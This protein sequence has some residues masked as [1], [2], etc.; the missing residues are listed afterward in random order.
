MNLSTPPLYSALAA[1]FSVDLVNNPPDDLPFNDMFQTVMG[2]GFAYLLEFAKVPGADVSGDADVDVYAGRLTV[3]FDP[4]NVHRLIGEPDDA[5]E[6]RR[7]QLASRAEYEKRTANGRIFLL[8]TG[9][10][11]ILEQ[12]PVKSLPRT[13]AARA[14]A[15]PGEK[16]D[17]KTD[18]EK[19]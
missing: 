2:D 4:E 7:K 15:R 16:T 6:R 17:D 19:E 13:G 11:E 10:L 9:L 14:S 3:T 1:P 8:K 12:P 5:F 18:E